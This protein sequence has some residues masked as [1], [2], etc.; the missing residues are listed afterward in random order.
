MMFGVVMLCVV[1]CI[2]ECAVA[3]LIFVGVLKCD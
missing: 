3:L 2:Y 1:A